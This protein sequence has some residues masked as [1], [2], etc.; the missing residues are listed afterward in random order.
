MVQGYKAQHS[1]F[2]LS[3]EL[4]RCKA[5]KILASATDKLLR[6]FI[7]HRKREGSQDLLRYRIEEN[8]RQ[9]TDGITKTS[10]LAL[11]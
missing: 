11:S 4:I 1:G 9:A 10:Q 2:I 3:Q 8:I 5:G 7:Q 6:E